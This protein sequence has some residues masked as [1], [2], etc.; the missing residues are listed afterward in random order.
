MRISEKWKRREAE[1]LK[2][3]EPLEVVLVEVVVVALVPVEPADVAPVAVGFSLCRA[4]E[5]AEA[6]EG[7]KAAISGFKSAEDMVQIELF[8]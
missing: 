7:V 1:K 5:V 3:V 4:A 8:M 6:E 2:G